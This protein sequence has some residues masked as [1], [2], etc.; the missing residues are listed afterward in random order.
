[1]K[2]LK[3]IRS[4]SER[5]KKI[6]IWIIVLLFAAGLG[7]WWAHDTS[8][9]LHHLDPQKAAQDMNLDQLNL[10]QTP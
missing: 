7:W 9:R 10:P 3:T 1:M 8:Y 4:Y 5:K 6:I 2:I